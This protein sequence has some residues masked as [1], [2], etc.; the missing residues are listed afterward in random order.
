VYNKEY[1]ASSTKQEFL[2]LDELETNVCTIWNSLIENFTPIYDQRSCNM[3]YISWDRYNLQ[4][5]DS[6]RML[7]Q[8]TDQGYKKFLDVWND[9][10]EWWDSKC[11]RMLDRSTDDFIPSIYAKINK[12]LFEDQPQKVLENFAIQVVYDRVPNGCLN[13]GTLFTIE[14]LDNFSNEDK[15]NEVAKR[16]YNLTCSRS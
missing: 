4:Q 10:S 9:F 13:K 5:K 6:Y 12:M 3:S 11:R 14:S 1:K 8:N 16:L 7:F 15:V 2:N